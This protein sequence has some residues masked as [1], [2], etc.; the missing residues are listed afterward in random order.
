M[1][2][3]KALGQKDA[4]RSRPLAAAA[5]AAQV[6]GSVLNTNPPWWLAAA[7][8]SSAR[9]LMFSSGLQGLLHTWF[10]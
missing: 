6:L 4:R 1:S 5:A 7:C 3:V 10:T 9:G 2:K 8:N